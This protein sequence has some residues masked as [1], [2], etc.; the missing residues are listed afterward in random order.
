MGLGFDTQST[1]LTQHLP[2]AFL[3][4]LLLAKLLAT[5]A[6]I[7]LGIPGGTIGPALFMGAIL[8]NLTAGLAAALGQLDAAQ[9]G[10]Y[11]LL[12]M[13]AMMGASLQAPLAALTAV[14]ELSHNPGMIM[15][16]MLAIILAAL[17]SRQ[18]FGKDSMFVTMLRANGLDYRANPVVQ[19]LR[20][21]GVAGVMS[22]SFS[23]QGQLLDRDKAQQLLHEGPEWLVVDR[24]GQP[25]C[26]LPGIA[27]A[28]HLAQAPDDDEIDLLAIPAE[29]LELASVHLQATLQEALDILESRGAEALYVRRPIAPGIE[30]IYGVLTRQR[31]E[32]AY[33]Y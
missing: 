13:G 28:A 1:L 17:T 10:F 3:L 15:P 8:G 2:L 18:V 23:R 21:S 16:G 27:V 29:R 5:S 24:D 31:I 20:R 11:A 22:T 30:H 4:V 7:G 32:S 33:R 19:M 25:S 12:G 9:A 14:V 6:S 26:L